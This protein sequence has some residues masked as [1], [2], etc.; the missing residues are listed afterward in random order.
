[1]LS[2]LLVRTTC[3]VNISMARMK[4]CEVPYT[5]IDKI[6]VTL[7]KSGC[8][9]ILFKE[10]LFLLLSSS[11]SL[12]SLSI[13]REKFSTMPWPN[14]LRSRSMISFTALII[15]NLKSGWPLIQWYTVDGFVNLFN[16]YALITIIIKRVK[17]YLNCDVIYFLGTLFRIQPK[18]K[19]WRR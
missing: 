12:M 8:H 2:L 15:C 5:I 11:C 7:S 17:L 3:I 19:L 9:I 16:R 4:L 14:P 18:T 6:A 13:A 1:M 10:L